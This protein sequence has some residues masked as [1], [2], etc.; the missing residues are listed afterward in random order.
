[1]RILMVS[2]AMV[3]ILMCDSMYFFS[4]FAPQSTISS[5]HCNPSTHPLFED[6]NF[7]NEISI[8][9][10][11]DFQKVPM[12][13]FSNAFNVRHSYLSIQRMGSTTNSDKV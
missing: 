10:P 2:F 13:H 11:N 5:S 7:L 9:S 1:M 8:A 12:A 6:G 4:Y 3:F